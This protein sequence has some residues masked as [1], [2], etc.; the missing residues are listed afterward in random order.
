MPDDSEDIFHN[1]MLDY[2]ICRPES[3]LNTS[4]YQFCAWYEKPSA[5][6]DKGRL[7]RFYIEKYDIWIKKKTQRL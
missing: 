7:E 3:L 6:T 4:Y 1:N 2:Y 5:P